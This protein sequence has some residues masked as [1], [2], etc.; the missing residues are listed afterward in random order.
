METCKTVQP[1]EEFVLDY[2]CYAMR[3]K[4]NIWFRWKFKGCAGISGASPQCG[5]VRMQGNNLVVLLFH[6]DIHNLCVL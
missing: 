6:A 1:R 2:F 4:R 5:Q 3:K